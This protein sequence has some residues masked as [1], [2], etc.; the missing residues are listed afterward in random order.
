MLRSWILFYFWKNI[1]ISK[2]AGSSTQMKIDNRCMDFL[3]KIFFHES[4]LR[5]LWVLKSDFRGLKRNREQCVTSLHLYGAILTFYPGGI[6]RLSPVSALC[7]PLISSNLWSI[8]LVYW[9][10]VLLENTESRPFLQ[11]DGDIYLRIL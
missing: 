10:K 1:F 4:S 11:G 7:P 9:K 5:I 8:L 6:A 3:K 2:A